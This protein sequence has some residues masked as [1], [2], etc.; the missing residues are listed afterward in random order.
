M[1]EISLKLFILISLYLINSGVAT[2]GLEGAEPSYK[3]DQEDWGPPLS[4][5]FFL[6]I[7]ERLNSNE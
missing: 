4:Y 1:P 3:R 2:R 6:I 7:A 5:N